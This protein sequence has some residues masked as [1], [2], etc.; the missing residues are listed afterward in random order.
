[1]LGSADRRET[2]STRE[3]YGR[4]VE[5]ELCQEVQRCTKRWDM[6]T[7]QECQSTLLPRPNLLNR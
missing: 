1:M 7:C 2:L 6:T 4:Q 3:W 5:C